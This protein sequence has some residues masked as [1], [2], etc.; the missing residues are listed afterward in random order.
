MPLKLT[1]I[2]SIARVVRIEAK[3]SEIF[4]VDGFRGAMVSIIERGC[5]FHEVREISLEVA[6]WIQHASSEAIEGTQSEWIYTICKVRTMAQI[7]SNR[8]GR[9][10]RLS[11]YEGQLG[12]LICIPQG[13]EK[14]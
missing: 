8:G 9:L 5:N 7:L 11:A 14:E 3:S 12:F 13:Q 2:D 10:L 4:E 6:Q 1:P